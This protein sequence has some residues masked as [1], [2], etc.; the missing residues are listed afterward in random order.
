M[1]CI[2]G[3]GTQGCNAETFGEAKDAEGFL[4]QGFSE[5]KDACKR[6][7]G[8]DDIGPD[9]IVHDPQVILVRYCQD[10]LKVFLGIH[11]TQRVMRIAQADHFSFRS[12][13]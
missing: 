2:Q 11:Q 9:L 1:G 13:I 4:V 6:T 7:F 5:R 10:V 8:I 3:S 12:N